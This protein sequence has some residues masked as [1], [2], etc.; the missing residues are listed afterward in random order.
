MQGPDRIDRSALRIALNAHPALGRAAICRLAARVEPWL[1]PVAPDANEDALAAELSV[2]RDALAMARAALPGAATVAAR[3]RRRASR[4]GAEIVLADDP[5][6][7]ERCRE[8]ALPP[9]VLYLQGSI[10]SGPAV[11]VVG[12]RRASRYG[13]E[14]A[15]WLGS[16][17]AAAGLVVVSGFARGVDQAAHRGALAADSGRTVAV[18]GCGLAA[19]Y[20]RHRRELGS[21][22]AG[23]GALLSEF[24]CAAGPQNWHFP[25]RNRLIA[26]L[27]DATVVVE[28]APRSGSLVTAR[29]ALEAG[30]EVLAVPGRIT[31]EL[32]LGTNQLLADG[33]TP[34]THPSDVLA[35]IGLLGERRA[36]AAAG[37]AAPPPP[38]LPPE[39]AALYAALDPHDGRGAEALARELGRPIDALVAALLEAELAGWAVRDPGGGYR[40]RA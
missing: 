24:P 12:S 22:I 40:R 26:V 4:L 3:E 13:L 19:D 7:P 38:G 28:A 18:L 36:A 11:A 15:T 29:L 8:L 20:P 14:V 27:A 23:R 10:P 1:A 21:A 37:A 5:L 31:D 6:Y 30:R 35:A 9:P 17:L 34:V 25:V 32:A 16:E 39:L 33:A 2:G